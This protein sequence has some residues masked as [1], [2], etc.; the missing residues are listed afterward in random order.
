M[1][2]HVY[3]NSQDRWYDL[4]STAR[5]RGAVLAVNAVTLDE[6]A[7]RLTPDIETATPGQRL[8]IL[9]R[10]GREAQWFP[11]ITRYAYDAISELKAS[12]V[13]PPELRSAGASLL[14]DINDYYNE[15]LTRSGR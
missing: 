5:M 10:A 15:A 7:D 2:L 11:N 4:R 13:R 9:T 6:L 14:A 8:A 3:R 12:R 1:D